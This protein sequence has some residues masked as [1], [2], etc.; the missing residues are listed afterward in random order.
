MATGTPEAEAFRYYQAF[1]HVVASEG[2]SF[3]MYAGYDDALNA[4]DLYE[5][6]D[7][8]SYWSDAAHRRVAVRGI[9]VQQ[10]PQ[11]AILGVPF[12]PDTV[13]PDNEGETPF[14]TIA[15]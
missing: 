4:V 9:A 15:A 7:A 1:G 5:I 2:F 6:H 8:T 10:E 12:D 11:I 13:A 14:W 3:G